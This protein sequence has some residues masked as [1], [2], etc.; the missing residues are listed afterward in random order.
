MIKVEILYHENENMAKRYSF[1]SKTT[2]ASEEYVR[3]ISLTFRQ[4][5]QPTDLSV[6]SISDLPNEVLQM[7][8]FR[9]LDD[10][11]IYNLGLAGNTRLKEISHDHVKGKFRKI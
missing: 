8:I 10:V 5:D 6:K 1:R 2:T 4:D 11:D 7:H 9:Y 3:G